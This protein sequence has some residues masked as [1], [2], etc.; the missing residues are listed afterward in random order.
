MSSWYNVG[1]ASLSSDVARG[2]NRSESRTFGVSQSEFLH[3]SMDISD[4]VELNSAVLVH[5]VEAK[6]GLYGSMISEFKPFPQLV[7][8]T[9]VVLRFSDHEKVVNIHRDKD[10]SIV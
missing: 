7:D 9:L 6:E 1:L 10:P 8:A 2:K 4:L 3:F 5:N